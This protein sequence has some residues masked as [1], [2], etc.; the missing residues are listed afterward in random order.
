MAAASSGEGRSK[1]GTPP[2]VIHQ[3]VEGV[4][5]PQPGQHGRPTGLDHPEGC[6]AARSHHPGLSHPGRSNA[7]R[8]RSGLDRSIWGNADQSP[9][10]EHP[11]L[12]KKEEPTENIN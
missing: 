8:R 7:A 3:P 12:S 1:K 4:Q 2:R 10:V 5:R 9:R 11:G 6:G